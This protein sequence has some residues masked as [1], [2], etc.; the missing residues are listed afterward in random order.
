MAKKGDLSAVLTELEAAAESLDMKVSYENLGNALAGGGL[1][2][3]KGSWRV[4]IDK[5]STVGERVA[6]LA[7][8]IAEVSGDSTPPLSLSTH[9]DAVVSRYRPR[10]RSQASA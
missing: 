3:V 4:I 5:R 7:R 1:C 2:K 8:G 10:P 6:T 9:A